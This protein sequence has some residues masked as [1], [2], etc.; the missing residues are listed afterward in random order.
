M[1]P[2][3]KQCWYSASARAQLNISQVTVPQEMTTEFI[4][5]SQENTWM[6]FSP[7]IQGINQPLSPDTLVFVR[8]LSR[9]KMFRENVSGFSS[10]TFPS[11]KQ[12]QWPVL[13]SAHPGDSSAHPGAPN[14]THFL[15][16][17]P[18]TCWQ[19]GYLI[20][21]HQGGMW[22][23]TYSAGRFAFLMILQHHH[24]LTHRIIFYSPTCSPTQCFWPRNSFPRK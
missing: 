10:M 1:L 13:L 18:A 20:P 17:W 19:A 15:G 4:A 6:H 8:G 21:L 16:D 2:E 22:F 9:M 7:S 14:K 11:P 23:D 5:S 24:L 3:K 12:T